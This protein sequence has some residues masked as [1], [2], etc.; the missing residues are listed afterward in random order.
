MYT[1]H[2]HI[3]RQIKA[4]NNNKKCLPHNVENK[5]IWSGFETEKNASVREKCLRVIYSDEMIFVEA[6]MSEAFSICGS[7][8]SPN[9][10]RIF[11]RNHNTIIQKHPPSN[12]SFLWH[13]ILCP[14]SILVHIVVLIVASYE[15][16]LLFIALMLDVPISGKSDIF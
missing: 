4:Y 13:S 6:L 12:A 14:G 3:V 9:T 5:R 15:G 8:L 10:T 16:A 2:T 11:A 1:I 7:T